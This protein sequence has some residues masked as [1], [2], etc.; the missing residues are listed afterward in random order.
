MCFDAYPNWMPGDPLPRMPGDPL[1]QTPQDTL[2]QTPQDA[3]H[4]DTQASRDEG[5]VQNLNLNMQ[6]EGD[7]VS[8]ESSEDSDYLPVGESSD[9]CLYNE[10]EEDDSDDEFIEARENKRTAA[11]KKTMTVR[12]EVEG[13]SSM[14][15]FKETTD[16]PVVPLQERSSNIQVPPRPQPNLNEM[17][18]SDYEENDDEV[19]T[20][21]ASEEGIDIDIDRRR[22]K[23][24]K[25]YNPQADIND[26]RLEVRIK[27]ESPAQFKKVIQMYALSNGVNIKWSR[28]SNKRMEVV[29]VPGCPWK[30]YASWYQS[31]LTFMIKNYISEHKCSRSLNNRQATVKWLAYYYMETFG[32]NPNWDVK[33]M[34]ADFQSK[35]YFPIG[36]TKCYRVR[37][38][39]LQGL[40]GS[41]E[42]HY[43][44]LGPY[45]A[46]LRRVNRGSLF[47]IICDRA[48][49]GAPLVF[50]RLYI[51][52]EA[53]KK[54]FL[55][56]CRPII[57]LDGCFLKTFLGGQL[58]TAIGTYAN[59]QMYPIS[60]AIVEGE[61]YDSWKWFL[62][63]LFDDLGVEQGYGWTIIS[64]QQKGLEHAISQRVSAAEHQNCA[65]H[66]YANWKKKHNGHLLKS[67]FWK[68]VRCTTQSDLNKVLNELASTSTQAHQDFIGIG[69]QK[70]CAAYINTNCKADVVTNNISKTFNGYILKTRSK[71]I[72]DMLEE[73]RRM[74]M[75][76][77]Y[78]KKEMMLK[79]T[80]SICP[81]IRKKVEKNKEESR[82]CFVIP[83][84]NSK[85]EV[86][87]IE[88]THIVS[89][90]N[91][92]CSYVDQYVHEYYKRKTYMKSYELCIEPLTGKD[93]WPDVGDTPILPPHIKKMPGRPKKKR[94]RE[95]HE[96]DSQTSRLS[97]RGSIM[98]CQRCFQKGH[99]KRTCDA[100]VEGEVMLM[101]H[102]F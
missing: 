25:A 80:N 61:N 10:F 19:I 27:F 26:V 5:E 67:L 64:D 49:T 40:R 12:V 62:G 42:D 85:F 63:M 16:V 52:F 59:N 89:L 29:C 83:C 53:L 7:Y 95:P 39:A 2:P 17:P 41:V 48:F 6:L 46:E 8:D 98:T 44:M 56:G 15:D 21:E 4:A 84:G 18:D 81:N 43:G 66:L 57:G 20:P 13:S 3:V 65:R 99:N 76:R 58:L 71:P 33:L 32:N 30:V 23:H 94:R 74:L 9:D 22:K 34:D 101:M 14:V 88:K 86:Q 77:I 54:G 78:M 72:I 90:S 73:I 100:H 24:S 35:F 70:F 93:T 79:C 36:K 75:Q 68:A 51:G 47:N 87:C 82:N 97:K 28:S 45:I 50:K 31:E 60:W 96:D 55:Q 1:P 11:I 102:I 91:H 38:A 92:S 37:A 69:L